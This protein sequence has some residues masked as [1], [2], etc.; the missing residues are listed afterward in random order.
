MSKPVTEGAPA[1]SVVVPVYR[2][3][4]TLPELK[5]RLT[6][7]L[8]RSGVSHELVLVV[9]GCRE[10]S[11]EAAAGLAGG[12]ARVRAVRLKRNY[13]Q[14]QAVMAGIRLARGLTVAVMDADLQD[15]PEAV[16]RLQ[17]GRASCRER[18]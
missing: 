2:N 18:V 6:E 10:G 11:F 8:D 12:D 3:A 1:V 9:D 16:P 5:R 4:A 7:A 13:G 14:N 15:P 17:I